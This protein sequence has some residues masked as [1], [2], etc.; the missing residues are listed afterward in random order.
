MRGLRA[1]RAA[2]LWAGGLLGVCAVAAGGL[3]FGPTAQ[4]Q[5]GAAPPPAA[6]ARDAAGDPAGGA[7]D[8]RGFYL[9]VHAGYD[10][11][12]PHIV[13]ANTPSPRFGGV[14]GGVQLGYDWQ[15]GPV[16]VGVEG[17]FSLTTAKSTLVTSNATI[18]G[19]PD[20]YAD[21]AGRLGYGF[22]NWLVFAKTGP[23]WM[24]EGFELQTA[25]GASCSYPPCT[26]S[27]GTYGWAGGG[28]IAYAVD[29]HWSA[30]LEYLYLDFPK[31]E[32]PVVSNGASFQ[33]LALKRTFDQLVLGLNYRF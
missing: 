3:G 27:N 14:L 7:A 11:A 20:D 30:K 13:V 22:G 9:G 15:W 16:V 29:A 6:A 18:H 28:G 2:G 4:A 5:T 10:W 24:K 21:L 26:G 1:S 17:E 32:H 33:V 19:L 8:W 23:A 25:S 12:F 31:I